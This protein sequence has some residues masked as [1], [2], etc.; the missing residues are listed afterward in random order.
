MSRH[1][2]TKSPLHTAASSGVTGPCSPTN[3]A[4]TAATAM[5]NTARGRL[6]VSRAAPA[7]ANDARTAAVTEMSA[8]VSASTM[9]NHTGR[10][11]HHATPSRCGAMTP[12]TTRS[13]QSARA[14]RC[15]R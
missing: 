7:R 15:Q 12:V 9:A 14:V 2:P 1:A 6:V 3:A 13:E 10:V 8:A 5:P 11:S 4:A